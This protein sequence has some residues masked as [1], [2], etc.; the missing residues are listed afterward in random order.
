ML[1][2]LPNTC[3]TITV[4]KMTTK[5]KQIPSVARCKEAKCQI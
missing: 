2:K 5:D 1:D 3:H 4:A